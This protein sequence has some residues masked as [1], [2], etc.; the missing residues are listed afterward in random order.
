M[1]DPISFNYV[2]FLLALPFFVVS[3]SYMHNIDVVYFKVTHHYLI[4]IIAIF[5]PCRASINIKEERR[6]PYLHTIQIQRKLILYE[7]YDDFGQFFISF[8]HTRQL[9]NHSDSQKFFHMKAQF[10]IQLN[11]RKIAPPNEKTQ[12]CFSQPHLL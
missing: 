7:I 2:I 1:L 12:I 9:V 10:F 5:S 3:Y 11:E 6:N 4:F 8:A